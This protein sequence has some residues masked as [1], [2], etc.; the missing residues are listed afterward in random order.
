M[1]QNRAYSAIP[2]DLIQPLVN[3]QWD[4]KASRPEVWLLL[5]FRLK[6]NLAA[7]LDGVARQTMW[8]KAAVARLWRDVKRS[9]PE[10]HETG[11]MPAKGSAT[12]SGPKADQQR[13]KS[14]PVQPDAIEVVEAQADQE[15]T[16][17]GPRARVPLDMLKER[18]TEEQI[19]TSTEDEQK[20]PTPAVPDS[21]FER[22]CE[23]YALRKG[24]PGRP[25]TGGKTWRDRLSKAVAVAEEEGHDADAVLRAWE[26]VMLSSDPSITRIRDPQG[27]DYRFG[28]GTKIGNWFLYC[29]QEHTR[30]RLLGLI[31]AAQDWR[32]E[33]EAGFSWTVEDTW[34]AIV[35]RAQAKTERGDWKLHTLNTDAMDEQTRATLTRMGGAEVLLGEIR[36]AL[37]PQLFGSIGYLHRQWRQRWGEVAQ[38]ITQR[39]P[40]RPQ[41]ELVAGREA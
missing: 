32:P 7:D 14:G 10:F 25:L 17:S 40:A 34:Q 4:A 12:A 29:G 3:R 22:F 24:G 13:T 31:E 6:R 2:D 18:E 38:E 9:Q 15:R 37:D 35:R 5:W 26:R 21:T 19:S 20:P 8:S 36:S 28:V 1:S 23:I 41:L 33:S 39:E 11:R 30:S 16:K 27:A